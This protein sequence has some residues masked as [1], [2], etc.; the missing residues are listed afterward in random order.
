MTQ[1]YKY[2]RSI[3][4]NVFVKVELSVS[5]TELTYTTT[6]DNG[7]EE[8]ITLSLDDVRNSLSFSA[9]NWVSPLRGTHRDKLISLLDWSDITK[10]NTL[11]GETSKDSNFNLRFFINNTTDNFT[12]FVYQIGFDIDNETG[13]YTD[14]VETVITGAT[15]SNTPLDWKSV[16]SPIQLTSAAVSSGDDNVEVTVTSTN[17]S[18]EKVYLK[19]VCGV[20]DR[21]EVKLT[22]GTGKFKVITSTLET[23]D[24]IVVKA[25]HKKFSNVTTF[26]KNIS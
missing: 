2:A 22:N 14:T 23:G 9:Q 8:T 1:V 26:T 19:Q 10:R 4:T 13:N 25:G 6:Q 5:E 20:L 12:D 16:F 21:I 7:Y 24:S 17:T 3:A 11:S 18:L 15:L